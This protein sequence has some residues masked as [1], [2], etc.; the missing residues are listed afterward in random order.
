MLSQCHIRD[1]HHVVR[2]RTLYKMC[3]WMISYTKCDI[4]HQM[5]SNVLCDQ[6]CGAFQKPYCSHNQFVEY[7]AFQKHTAATINWAFPTE[8]PVGKLSAYFAW[9]A[10]TERM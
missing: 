6:E 5:T 2:L 7:A 3:K 1:I 10:Q 4:I 9:K 8:E